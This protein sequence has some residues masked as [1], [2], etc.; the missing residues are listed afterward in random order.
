MN[1]RYLLNV[2][3][4]KRRKIHQKDYSNRKKRKIQYNTCFHDVYYIY[5]HKP[6]NG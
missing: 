1:T 6:V 3:I 5:I 4:L 2:D